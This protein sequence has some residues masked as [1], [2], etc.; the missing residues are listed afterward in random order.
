MSNLNKLSELWQRVITALIGGTLILFCLAYNE[1]TYFGIFFLVCTLTMRE[2]FKLLGINGNLP[3]KSYGTFLGLALYT[4]SFCVEKKFVTDTSYYFLLIGLS[5]TYMIKLYSKRDVKPFRSIAYTFLGILYVALPFSLM[6]KIVLI[7]QHYHFEILL[8][9]LFIQWAS[10]SGAYFSG[11]M[12]GKHKLFERVSPK[13]TWEGSIGGAVCA[14][15]VSQGCAYYW[16][17]LVNWQWAAIAGIIVVAGTYGD[18]VESLF[19]RSIKI[20]DSG[21]VLP[22]HGGFLDRFDSILIAMPFIVAFVKIV[23]HP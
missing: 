9:S 6:H 7:E 3:L 17:I 18:L 15:L 5:S 22:G 21:H 8:G 4:I 19:K 2:F 13:K 14:L 11:R 12:L 10:D 23:V 16:D 20:K 1:W